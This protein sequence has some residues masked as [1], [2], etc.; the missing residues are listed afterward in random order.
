LESAGKT[1]D[2]VRLL[3]PGNGVFQAITTP[4]HLAIDNKGW[5]TENARTLCTIHLLDVGRLDIKAI[6]A[7][8]YTRCILVYLIQGL[9]KIGFT[10]CFKTVDKLAPISGLHIICTPAFLHG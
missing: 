3:C 2:S 6:G 10:A 7:L 1:D 5:A 9:R 4:E 8:D